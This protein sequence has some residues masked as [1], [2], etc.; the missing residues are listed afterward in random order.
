MAKRKNVTVNFYKLESGIDTFY[1][2]LGIKL[3]ALA[4]QENPF[5]FFDGKTAE[6]MFTLHEPI[7]LPS[8]G[9][10]LH[11]IS[12]VKEKVFLPVKFD[13]EGNVSEA[14]KS[15]ETLGDIAY[16][17]IDTE[18]G[19]LLAL[20]GNSGMF[21][22]FLRWLSGDLALETTPMFIGNV[23]DQVNQWE[24]FR[25][26]TLGTEAPA[27]DFVNTILDSDAGEYCYLLEA[28]SGLK[29]EISVSMGHSKGSLHKDAVKE[30]IKLMMNGSNQLEKLKIS[31]KS[32]EEQKTEEHDLYDARLKHKREIVIAGSHIS[33]D[34]ARAA[35]Y[36][37]Y[38]LHLDEIEA[39]TADSEEEDEG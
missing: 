18:N 7:K 1:L 10:K 23:Y 26:V 39:D 21:S 36:E 13:R 31:G 27:M 34:E 28:L 22:D 29:I 33:P 25:K 4:E 6:L 24:I 38:Q 16:G 37:A 5:G 19:A 20:G 11:I 8:A 32:F 30:F 35:L 14:I 2:D 17:L 15:P 12:I 9:R 3:D